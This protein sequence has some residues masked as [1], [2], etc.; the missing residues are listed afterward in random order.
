LIEA[1]K[2][3]IPTYSFQGSALFY[4]PKNST[5][6][7]FPRHFAMVETGMENSTLDLTPSNYSSWIQ[8]I[9]NYLWADVL[10]RAW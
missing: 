8:S 1:G 3:S 2:K 4:R 9:Q 5:S 7:I 10:T 6:W